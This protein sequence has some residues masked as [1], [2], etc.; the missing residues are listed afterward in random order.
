MDKKTKHGKPEDF[1][2]HHYNSFQ[3]ESIKYHKDVLYWILNGLRH[4]KL[5]V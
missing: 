1:Y 5:H 3:L 4:E 2:S